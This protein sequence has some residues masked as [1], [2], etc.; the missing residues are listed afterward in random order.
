[1]VDEQESV[2]FLLGPVGML[3]T[4]YQVRPAEVGL[5]FVESG[6][7]LPS[8]D[9]EGSQ[10]RVRGLVRV[11]DCGEEPVDAVMAGD[12]VL[13]RAYRHPTTGVVDVAPVE[14]LCEIRAVRQL[15][16][17]RQHEVFADSP[18][19]VRP[20]GRGLAPQVHAAKATVGQQQHPR[21]QG[22]QAPRARACSPARRAPIAASKTAWVPHSTRPTMRNCG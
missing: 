15:L 1:M 21:P 20:R 4:Q 7:E 3:G 6:L 10:F 12:G 9:V 19:Q 17:H 5:D 18:Q 8:L 16:D 2:E 22:H 13:H 11:E 14:D